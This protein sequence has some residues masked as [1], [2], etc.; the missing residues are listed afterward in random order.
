MSRVFKIP[1]AP[2][3]S[4]FPLSVP[5]CGRVL[6]QGWMD[7][8]LSQH[9]HARSEAGGQG[10][11]PVGTLASL[12]CVAKGLICISRAEHPRSGS[13]PSRGRSLPLSQ[14][15]GELAV[16]LE[17]TGFVPYDLVSSSLSIFK[18]HSFSFP[19]LQVI[20]LLSVFHTSVEFCS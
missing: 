12:L 18:E 15:G 4:T 11:R 20:N 13:E 8:G 1:P 7:T 17:V 19:W 3:F 9:T 14:P 5:L 10:L 6:I 16:S 2:R